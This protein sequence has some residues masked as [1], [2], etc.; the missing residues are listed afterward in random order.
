MLS[1]ALQAKGDTRDKGRP[2]GES[3]QG[4]PGICMQLCLAGPQV[5]GDTWWDM[6][7]ETRADARLSRTRDL[8]FPL[9]LIPGLRAERLGGPHLR[10]APHCEESH[11]VPG[12]RRSGQQRCAGAFGKGGQWGGEEGVALTGPLEPATHQATS[13]PTLSLQDGGADG[14]RVT[15]QPRSQ[16]SSQLLPAQSGFLPRSAWRL[17]GLRLR[18]CPALAFPSFVCLWFRSLPPFS[19]SLSH[20]PHITFSL[21]TCSVHLVGRQ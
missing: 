14:G 16:P 11:E 8:T 20:T 4:C 2:G 13:A 9:V 3:E 6:R 10:Q 18:V 1:R 5:C 19:A 7:Q 17:Q 21:P 15:Q 12:T